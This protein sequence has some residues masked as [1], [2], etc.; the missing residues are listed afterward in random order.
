MELRRQLA[1]AIAASLG[2]NAQE[3]SAPPY[4]IP[5]PRMS[6]LERGVV[7]RYRAAAARRIEQGT[8]NRHDEW[9]L[10]ELR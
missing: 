4:G 10:R 7:G 2:P 3:V 1:A 5:Q 9:V 6:Q 8:G